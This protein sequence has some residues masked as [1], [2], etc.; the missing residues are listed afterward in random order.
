MLLPTQK[1]LKILQP[2]NAQAIFFIDMMYLCRLKETAEKFE[3]AKNDFYKI[4][5][6]LIEMAEQGHYVFNHLHPHWLDAVYNPEK[7]E[8]TLLNDSKYAFQSLTESEQ[9]FVFEKTLTLLNEILLKAKAHFTPDGYRAGGLYIQ[10]FSVFKKYFEQYRIK[11]DFSVLLNATGKLSRKEIAFDFSSVKKCIYRFND[12]ITVETSDGA[13]TEFALKF[14]ET[15]L[16]YRL[17]NSLFYRLFMKGSPFQKYGDGISTSH[18]ISTADKSRFASNETF[19]VEM[20]NAVKLPLYLKEAREKKYLHL[21][22]H[23]KLVSAYNLHIFDKLLYRL[24]SS[25]SC[26]FDFKKFELT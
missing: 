9:N 22:S 15:P 10:P 6:Q 23:P 13:F 3:Q 7:N 17:A 20:L 11:Y 8:W 5:K 19:S 4:E 2:H 21:L 25:G 24:K 14:V 16:L 12:D 1:I 26:E 18:K